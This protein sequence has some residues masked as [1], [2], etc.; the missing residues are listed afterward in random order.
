V[1]RRWVWKQVEPKDLKIARQKGGI[2]G[3]KYLRALYLDM[4]LKDAADIVHGKSRRFDAPAGPIRRGKLPEQKFVP[5]L[6][7]NLDNTLIN[8]AD[9]YR[10]RVTQVGRDAVLG[11]AY[12]HCV[13]FTPWSQVV[14]RMNAW[15]RLAN[16][17]RD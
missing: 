17:A 13:Q 3:I 16:E 9:E 2:E 11:R 5:G 6:P 14:E 10:K 12:K 8:L 4:S 15:E 7:E 1:S